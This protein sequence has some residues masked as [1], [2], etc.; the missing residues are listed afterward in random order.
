M[1]L[2]GKSEIKNMMLSLAVCLL[3]VVGK[4]EEKDFNQQDEKPNVLFIAIDDLNDWTG[5]PK[6]NPQ[7]RFATV[8]LRQ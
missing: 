3:C 2:E 8:H 1:K 5:V 4:I 7:A 6:G